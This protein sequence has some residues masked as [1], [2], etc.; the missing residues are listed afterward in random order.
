MRIERFEDIEAWQL[1]LAQTPGPALAWQ[2]AVM[3]SEAFISSENSCICT[4][5]RTRAGWLAGPE[6]HRLSF[7]NITATTA[8]SGQ[9]AP[10][11]ANTPIGATH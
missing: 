2:D 7:R 6:F 11:Q 3:Q 4:S 5:R 9:V 8:Y 10:G 1:A